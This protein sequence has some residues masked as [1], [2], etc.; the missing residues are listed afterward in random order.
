MANPKT[1]EAAEET[2]DCL[3]IEGSFNG[4]AMMEPEFL[5]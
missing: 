3:G 4:Q 2:I 1:T 5:I